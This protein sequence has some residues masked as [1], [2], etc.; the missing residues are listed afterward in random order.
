[1]NKQKIALGF[2]ILELLSALPWYGVYTSPIAF[3]GSSGYWSA[4]SLGTNLLAIFFLLLPIL[5]VVGLLSGWRT[6]FLWMGLYPVV[7][8]LFGVVPIPFATHLYSSDKMLNT[9]LI[10]A[11]D[12]LAVLITCWLYWSSRKRSNNF[13]E[14]IP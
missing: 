6:A 13:F 2:A 1:M 12:I 4:L 11:I 3:Y 5:A 8:F 14:P 10:G 7:A 9:Y